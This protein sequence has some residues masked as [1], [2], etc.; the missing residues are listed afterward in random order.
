[1]QYQTI[2]AIPFTKNAY[3]QIEKEYKKLKKE[4]AEV[5]ERLKTAREMGD[6][7]ENGAYKYAKFELGNIARQ[8]R[9]LNHL[10]TNGVIIEKKGTPTTVNFGST[11][12]VT[13]G[14]QEMTFFMVSAHE[15]DISKQKLSMDSPLG[16][17]L[18]GK[19]VGDTTTVS[20]PSG[21][22]TYTIVSL[23]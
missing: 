4:R 18:M 12:T 19:S 2:P 14:K 3:E 5:M 16:A 6:L 8:L 22:L 17:G 11:V 1:M 9:S 20:A 23:L 15:S 7:S 13:D 10:L 21:Q